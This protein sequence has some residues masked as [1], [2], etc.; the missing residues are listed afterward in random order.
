MCCCS[1]RCAKLCKPD[2]NKE[3][4]Y[5]KRST[6]KFVPRDSKDWVGVDKS[7]KSSHDNFSNGT[8]RSSPELFF[9]IQPAPERKDGAKN[10]SGRVN[11]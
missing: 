1:E 10:E 4:F 2:A 3:S 6:R 11:P 8:A 7:R 5:I 9:T